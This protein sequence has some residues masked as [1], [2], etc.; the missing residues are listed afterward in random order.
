MYIAVFALSLLAQT[1]NYP[2]KFSPAI[3]QRPDVQKA[4]AFVDANFE[5]QQVPEWIR[6]TEIP[7]PS[8]KEEKRGAYVK[9][10]LEKL[11]YQTVTDSIGNLHARRKGTGKGPTLVFA[12][13]LD[14]V[15]PENT[16]V[17]VTRKP[18]GTLH[19]PGVGDNTIAVAGLLQAIRAMDA[20]KMQT[21]GDI[22]FLFSVQEEVGLKGMYAWFENNRKD[23]DL[24]VALDSNLGPVGYGALGIYW[25]RMKFTGPGAHTN[26]SK[27]APNPVRAAAQCITDI[28][29]VPIPDGDPMLGTVYNVGG[30]M[31]SGNIVNAVPQE[32]AFTVDLRTI[33]KS[34][35]GQLD[36]AIVSKCDSAARAFGVTFQREWIQKS[37]PG[38]TPVQ[39]EDRRK[40]P[41]VQT[42]IDVTKYVGVKLLPGKE[43]IASGSTDANVGVVAGIPSITVG[44][45]NGA[46]GHTLT[47]WANIE[48]ART[49]TKLILLLAASLTEN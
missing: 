47:E 29:T 2:T 41:L 27:G 6:L 48:S 33:D 28:Y 45:G 34:V 15:F 31:S 37:E 43:A 19:A 1:N 11:G 30:M 13:H 10:E 40:H 3:A 5:S 4:T 20:A 46:G 12:S 16:N 25:S 22:I 42:A 39:L 8:G 23:T 21:T 36:D 32:V 18:D 7:A 49:G 9:A 24:L 14:T 38:G 35:M 17:K 44:R 26:R